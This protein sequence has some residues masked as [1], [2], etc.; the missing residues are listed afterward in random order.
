[1][2]ATEVAVVTAEEGVADGEVDVET[3]EAADGNDDCTDIAGRLVGD[4]FVT[5]NDGFCV[6][7]VEAF[8]DGVG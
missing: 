3:V 2:E 8:V 1:V 7:V 4:A 6:G 5:A